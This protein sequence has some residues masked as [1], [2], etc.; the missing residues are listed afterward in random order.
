MDQRT[1]VLRFPA[2]YVGSTNQIPQQKELYDLKTKTNYNDIILFPQGAEQIFLE[3]LD[4]AVDAILDQK[5]DKI[6]IIMDNNKVSITNY[7]CMIPIEVHPTSGIYTPELCFGTFNV[8]RNY[9]TLGNGPQ[10]HNGCGSKTANVFSK[11]FDVVI[12]D[13]NKQLKYSQKWTDNMI[14]CEQPIIEKYLGNVSFVQ[15]SYQMDFEIF[16]YQTTGCGIY[17]PEALSLFAKH[18]LNKSIDHQIPIT[19]NGCELNS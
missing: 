19:F 9:N 17:P 16:G 10:R 7:G 11:L 2:M 8:S 3:I 4:N 1:A 5:G 6:D 15:V 18:A 12:C 14:N 13:H